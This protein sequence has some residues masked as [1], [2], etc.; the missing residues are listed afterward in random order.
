MGGVCAQKRFADRDPVNVIF[1]SARRILTCLVSRSASSQRRSTA[2]QKRIRSKA[3]RIKGSFFLFF[4]FGDSTI[5]KVHFPYVCAWPSWSFP[6]S[7]MQDKFWNV[8]RMSRK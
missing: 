6:A 3:H 8:R 4:F 1:D 7:D 5:S 2:R